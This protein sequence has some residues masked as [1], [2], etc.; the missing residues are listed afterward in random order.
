VRVAAIVVNLD[1]ATDLPACIA[2]LRAQDLPLAS[3]VVVDNASSDDSLGVLAELAAHDHPVPVHIRANATNRGYAGGAND[4]LTQ[5]G[6]V[7]AVLIANP[8]VGVA[9]DYLR[10]AVAALEA[11]DRRGAIQGRLYRRD[12]TPDGDR[13]LDTTGHLAFRTR[14]FHN[15]GGGEVDHGQWSESGEVFGVSGALALYRQAMLDDV[16]VEVPVRD[17]VRREVFD[18]DLFAFWED[19]DLDWRAAMRGWT[20]WYEPAAVAEHERGGAGPR[21]TAFVEQ[22]NFTNRLLML[23]KNDT[24][25]ALLPVLPAVLLTTLLK[26]IE[27]IITSPRAAAGALWRLRLVGRMRR[28]RTAIHGAAT[29][30]SPDVVARWFDAFSYRHWISR[31][32]TRVRG[33]RAA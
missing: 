32:W 17:G 10:H 16:A 22:L 25:R 18:E 33:G 13:V 7:D 27:L 21:R 23:V 9:P 14:L 28:K 3:I 20:C 31:W 19:V 2:S 24:W 29:V 30:P 15:R 8:D 11:D 12:P 26:F 6:A 1:G 5:V 4:G